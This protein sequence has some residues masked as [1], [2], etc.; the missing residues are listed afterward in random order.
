MK[1]KLLP[2]LVR[3]SRTA[4]PHSALS[5]ILLAAIAA[6]G[7]GLAVNPL[8]QR[9]VEL[10]TQP[11]APQ[12]VSDQS[13]MEDDDAP[14]GVWMV[15][16]VIV[17]SSF[18]VIIVAILRS[19]IQAHQLLERT[20]AD[21]IRDASKRKQVEESLRQSEERARLALDAGQMGAWEWDMQAQVQ[22]WDAGQ[23]E[24]FGLD[25]TTT[26]LNQET[27]FSLVHPDDLSDLKRSLTTLLNE[28]GSFDIEF[29]ICKP[30]GTIRWLAGKGRLV[31]GYE[32][33]PLRMIG[34]NF[35]I[36]ERKQSDEERNRLLQAEQAARA[37]AEAVN[38]I[39]DEF[40]ATLSHELRSPLNAMLGWLTLLRTRELDP[41]TVERALETVERNARA[42]AQ[43]VEDLLDVSR[44]I[45]GQL[46]LAIAPVRLHTVIEAALDTVRP[47]ADAKNIHLHTQLDTTISPT[48]G[49]Y[50]RVQQIIWNLLTN[51][52]K[53]TPNGGAVK[54]GLKQLDNCAQI[55]VAD[56]GKGISTEFLPYVFERFRQAD[57]SIT[58][59][60]GGLGLG[61]A[62]VRHLVELH[63]GTVCVFSDGE[64]KGAT[65]TVT[66]PLRAIEPDNR[67]RPYAPLDT[68]PRP[69]LNAKPALEGLTV[70]VVDDE[71]DARELLVHILQGVG[72]TVVAVASAE[73][74]IAQ[75][76]ALQSSSRFDL[77]VSDIGMPH[78][79]GYTLLRRLRSLPP[80]QGGQLPALALT[81]YARAEDRQAAYDAGFQAH[82]AKPVEPAQL[83]TAIA[84][85]G[86]HKKPNPSP[87]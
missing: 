65:F 48:L 20:R 83:V 35:D 3:A 68:Y 32:G 8:E 42:Q 11:Q 19:Q 56:T 51:A 61:L 74:A 16:L 72:A 39:K 59:S 41:A 4:L 23:Y 43:L 84:T 45:R 81:A 67:A 1:F 66:L 31:Q 44:I 30:D 47:A 64:G 78:E 71:T 79:D 50:N 25:P 12:L 2:I 63:G 77:L 40:L 10:S 49:D 17:G 60:Y 9:W 53:F 18:S 34:V 87:L 28:G 70:L 21:S 80:D 86:L 52:I 82:L 57:S 36:T 69:S 24:L 38:R 55:T 46:Q 29:R 14:D 62:I 5:G 22:H 58:R 75:L 7:I 15:I 85:L 54:I 73:D 6:M 33:Q 76:S 37:E 27:F 26:T 13:S